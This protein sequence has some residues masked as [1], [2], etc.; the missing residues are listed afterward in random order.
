M[1]LKRKEDAYPIFGKC[2]AFT[3]DPF[4]RKILEGFIK[5][6]FPRGMSVYKGSIYL[7]KG[8]LSA[9][10][11]L[12]QTPLVIFQELIHN[13]REILEFY[14]P[15]ER[16]RNQ[17]DLE[18]ARK[19][20]DSVL[21]G[22]W[23]KI[24]KKKYREDIIL[25]YIEDIKVRLRLNMS[26]MNH[27][28]RVIHSGMAFHT[29]NTEDFEYQNG[30]I[31]TINGLYWD[32]VNREFYTREEVKMPKSSAKEKSKSINPYDTWKKFLERE[33]KRNTSNCDD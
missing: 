16:K 26:E 8:S 9:Q 14:S 29:I 10:I 13:L 22:E 32:P 6:K 12:N 11:N 21:S 5:G 23:K 4:W 27:L 25:R 1:V 33:H 20:I 18:A 3:I 17:K 2:L 19:E 24:K 15:F 28:D 7:K 30:R 31:V